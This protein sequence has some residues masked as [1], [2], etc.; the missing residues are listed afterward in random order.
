MSAD[1]YRKLFWVVFAMVF[2]AH[3]FL[4]VDGNNI[5][6]LKARVEALEASP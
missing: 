6:D 3:V 5:N 2:V 4:L 1:D